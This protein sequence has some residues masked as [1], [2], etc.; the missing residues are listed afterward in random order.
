VCHEEFEMPD[1]ALCPFH[2]GA[3]CSLCCT[4]ESSCKDVCKTDGPG[5]DMKGI[6]L[7][8]AGVAG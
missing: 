2:S 3:I 5:A 8:M 4:L 7:P 1:V 6:A